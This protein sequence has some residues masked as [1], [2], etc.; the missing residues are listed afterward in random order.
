MPVWYGRSVTH[1]YDNTPNGRFKTS[2][3]DCLKTLCETKDLFHMDGILFNYED[4]L[5]RFNNTLFKLKESDDGTIGMH[6]YCGTGYRLCTR[7]YNPPSTK[8]DIA[9]SVVEQT[10]KTMLL[11]MVCRMVQMEFIAQ[12][13]NPLLFFM[14]EVK[15]SDN[16]AVLIEANANG[17][18]VYVYLVPDDN[19]KWYEFDRVCAINR[20]IA[21][22]CGRELEGT[23]RKS[24]H[25]LL[26]A[27][28]D[29]VEEV[30]S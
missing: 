30:S 10:A 15:A 9:H 22:A 6:I 25:G 4:F 5:I 23:S 3:F 1:L 27:V 20:K 12:C 2:V 18:D 8:A 19:G 28:N 13:G 14:G 21:K 16:K 24:V 29:V 26:D 7:E 11:H 17:V